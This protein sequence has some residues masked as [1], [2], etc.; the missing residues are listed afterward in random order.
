MRPKIPPYIA[1]VIGVAAVSFAAIFIK[2]ASAP[3]AVV[4]FYRMGV[5]TLI[6][7]PF[8]IAKRGKEFRTLTKRQIFLLV[9]GGLLL[10]LHFIFWISS[11]AH[12]SVASSVIFV[13]TQPIFVAVAAALILKEKP[14]LFLLSG[15]ALACVG[16]LVIGA[17]DLSLSVTNLYGDLMALGGSIMAAGYFL[18]GRHLRKSLSLGVY[19]LSVYGFCSLF[20]LLYILINQIH[21]LGY[22]SLTWFSMVMLAL[23]PTIIG[24]TSLNWALK[25][26]HAS[27]VSASILGEPVGAT[28]LAWL[29]LHEKPQVF[30]LIGGILIL[31]GICLTSL[32]LEKFDDSLE[33]KSYLEVSG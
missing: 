17:G 5:A 28:L 21:L 16:S 25:Y 9:L 32:K 8:T 7:A 23:V 31:G 20:L 30:T 11:F 14:G 18:V 26:L 4:A 33:E 29:I 13:T 10:S 1:L 27:V 3:P 15:I 2:L 6:L 22:D 12:T 19:I 24:H